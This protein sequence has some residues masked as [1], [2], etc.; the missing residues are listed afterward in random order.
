MTFRTKDGFIYHK[1]EWYDGREG[2]EILPDGTRIETF[3]SA[4]GPIMNTAAGS[5][6][7]EFP[8]TDMYYMNPL[9]TVDMVRHASKHY[10]FSR[11][12][13]QIDDFAFSGAYLR[14]SP[15]EREA[16]D[17][18][19]QEID[20]VQ[21]KV[22]AIDRKVI[23]TI[24][25]CRQAAYD[26]IIYG[27]V[28][29]E[30]V[31]GKIEGW[32]AP[33]V[34]KRLPA[35]SF[36]ERPIGRMDIMRYIVGDILYGIVFDKQ[37]DTFEFWQKQN[38]ISN[39]IMIPSRNVIHIRDEVSEQVDGNSLLVQILPLIKKLEF[40]DMCLMQTVHRAGAPLLWM[41]V[42][43][44]P[45]KHGNLQN[46]PAAWDPK[47]AYDE[48]KKI[49][50][51]WGKDSV[52]IANSCITPVPLDF[53]IAIDPIR[54]VQFL[55]TR[56]LYALIPRD[57]TE[58]SGQA[59]SKTSA[60]TLKLLVLVADGWRAR[61]S[62]P[63]TDM[64]AEIL[65][66]N[67]YPGWTVEIVW[68]ELDPTDEKA[69]YDR[70]AVANGMGIFTEDEI[71]E[72]VG[73][74]PKPE[75]PNDPNLPENQLQQPVL[76]ENGQPVIGQDG[77][78][79]Y[80][81]VAPADT[82][83]PNQGKVAPNQPTNLKK[84]P[85]PKG[86]TR[87]GDL[88]QPN[89]TLPKQG[90]GNKK[91]ATTSDGK[92]VADRQGKP[93]KNSRKRTLPVTN[94]KKGDSHADLEKIMKEK[95]RLFAEFCK[96]NGYLPWED[97]PIPQPIKNSWDAWNKA[98]PG[99]NWDAWNRAHMGLHDLS[100]AADIDANLGKIS[101]DLKAQGIV[102]APFTFLG[103]TGKEPAMGKTLSGGT[104]LVWSAS[105]V[106]WI[107]PEAV[108]ADLNQIPK[109]AQGLVKAVE[110]SPY[111]SPDEAA[112]MK[113]LGWAKG[114][115]HIRATTYPDMKAIVIWNAA[116]KNAS[117]YNTRNTIFHEVG[118]LFN[119]KRGF[120][121]YNKPYADAFSKDLKSGYR[122]QWGGYSTEYA[123]SYANETPTPED[124]YVEDFAE[125]FALVLEGK[126]DNSM[127]NRVALIQK[128]LSEE[129][130][131]LKRQESK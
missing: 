120:L 95:V 45:D 14:A 99:S 93:V 113:A 81:P 98:H 54:V 117:S 47:R 105:G 50:Q 84:Q 80:Q 103:G 21:A 64:W 12:M 88:V 102:Q 29:F 44:Y 89:K 130:A 19:E 96:V 101:A 94:S 74:E 90:K 22:D 27:T 31:K 60:P 123:Q 131:A 41:K 82:G 10:I 71:R 66:E 111:V 7:M 58:Q 116:D 87:M 49:G 17:I 91:T 69:I 92:D 97:K 118:H 38:Q 112:T 119:Q 57:F 61:A 6:G 75:D 1:G 62:K 13:R 53:K 67:G 16:E 115:G 76:D 126:T 129:E 73:Y 70:A 24:T 20:D 5:T 23:K 32:K 72:M 59:V 26:E 121:S 122:Q 125:T 108:E 37:T 63:F 65:E 128:E 79:V 11:I 46:A 9:I 85:G 42:E 52:L 56:I 77:Q 55:E 107:N 100:A 109:G 78:P 43:E 30:K 83:F 86:K 33:V 114:T 104:K 127:A 51:N 48:G 106:T 68:K 124:K 3:L 110:I 25:R 36:C 35:Y 18:D 34:V 39:P 4:D 8:N 40:A 15:P 28:V 2:V